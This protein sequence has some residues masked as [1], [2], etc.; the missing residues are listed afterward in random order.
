[1]SQI[2]IGDR[3]RDIWSGNQGVVIEGPYKT[4]FGDRWIVNTYG[5]DQSIMAG[6]LV[7]IDSVGNDENRQETDVNQDGLFALIKKGFRHLLAR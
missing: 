3:V 1:M 2:K 4:R 7:V 6:D 5:F